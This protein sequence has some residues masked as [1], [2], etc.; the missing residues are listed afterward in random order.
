MSWAPIT[1]R[2]WKARV[3]K[4][5]GLRHISST[6]RRL[7]N[8]LLLQQMAMDVIPTPP[9]KEQ[10]EQWLTLQRSYLNTMRMLRSLR[11]N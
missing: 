5:I 4:D 8:Q 7:L 9:N 10:M 11:H 6:Q 3:A 2:R 1:R